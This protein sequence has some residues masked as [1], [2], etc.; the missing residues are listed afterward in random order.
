VTLPSASFYDTLAM[1]ASAF[2][3]PTYNNFVTIAVSWLFAR[4]RH[5]ISQAAR[6]G[7]ALGFSK[8]HSVLY[9]FFSR[10]KWTTDELGRQVFFR[11]LPF[12][13]RMIFALVDDTL[14]RKTGPHLWGGGMHHDAAASS[15]GRCSSGRR[16]VAFAFGHNWVILAIW[17]PLPWNPD[18]GVAIPVL[19]RIYRSKRTS[20]KQDY[21]K[22][23]VL[24]FE[25]LQV[26]R[27]WTLDA[28]RTV[29]VIGDSEY[30]CKTLVKKLPSGFEFTGPIPLDAALFDF[31]EPRRKGQRGATRKKGRQLPSPKK[32]IADDSVPWRTLK[33]TLYGRQVS[34]L[35]KSVECLWYRVSGTR[36]VRVVITRDPDGVLDDR[37]FFSTREG[38]TQE[39]L[40]SWFSRRWS[41]EVTFYNAKQSLGLEDPQNGWWRRNRKPRGKKR[42]GPQARGSRGR[43]A[44]ERTAP[45]ILYL[46]GT[47]YLWY[48][49]HGDPATDVAIARAQAPWYRQKTEP[50]FA[51]M[52]TA[53]KR[54][55]E[56][57]DE[58]PIDPV[59]TWV[60][61]EL[62]AGRIQPMPKRVGGG[63]GVCERAKL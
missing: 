8:H 2:T 60:M 21:R 38:I 17:V 46:L 45:V 62:Q 47:I 43:R 42:P 44:V 39:E 37:A 26:L 34:I 48:F 57:V 31:P 9:R 27:E 20:P 52:L 56:V 63:E 61:Q 40:L 12:V 13:G 24:A 41:L 10:A 16:H 58:L 53:L 54:D 51:D 5:T 11:C 49:E 14:C 28:G 6:V 59:G 3:T 18:R 22:R 15:Y 29:M 1:F 23:T 55:L 19:F 50:C 30:S 32:M 35:V 33:A 36:R 4:D 25:M 7:L